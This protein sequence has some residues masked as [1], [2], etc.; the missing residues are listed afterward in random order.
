MSTFFA[1]VIN[2][3]RL[4]FA[5]RGGPIALAQVTVLGTWR[6]GADCS[7]CVVCGIFLFVALQR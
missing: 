1:Q 7:R 2:V 4:Y 5:D 6:R 3:T